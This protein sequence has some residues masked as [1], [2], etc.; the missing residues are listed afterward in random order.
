MARSTAPVSVDILDVI[1]HL[2]VSVRVRNL[3]RLR[4]GLWLIALAAR[5]MRCRIDVDAAGG[6]STPP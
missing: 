5:I 2:T 3:W 1:D 6:E 4:L